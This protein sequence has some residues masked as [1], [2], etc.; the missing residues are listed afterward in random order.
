MRLAPAMALQFG[1]VIAVGVLG[2][3]SLP[4]MGH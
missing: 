3:P 1:A 4:R 2:W